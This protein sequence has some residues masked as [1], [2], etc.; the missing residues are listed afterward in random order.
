[1]NSQIHTSFPASRNCG[2]KAATAFAQL[3][4]YPFCKKSDNT[5]YGYV[6]DGGQE[7][8]HTYKVLF[9]GGSPSPALINPSELQWNPL[10]DCPSEIQPVR[11][12]DIQMS[13]KCI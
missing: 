13:T 2:R 5:G 7:S 12:G 10:L 8:E 3:P 4:H 1:M 9:N 11:K 6:D